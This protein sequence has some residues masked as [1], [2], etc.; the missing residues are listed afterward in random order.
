MK[1]VIKEVQSLIRCFRQVAL[2]F[3]E[4][5]CF[6]VPQEN[7]IT[8]FQSTLIVRFYKQQRPGAIS[9]CCS[10]RLVSGPGGS[11]LRT[12][13]KL[14]GRKWRVLPLNN[15]QPVP[16]WARFQNHTNVLKSVD[17]ITDTSG[18]RRL[19]ASRQPITST[20]R[21]WHNNEWDIFQ[22]LTVTR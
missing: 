8:M 19:W 9:L 5:N 2:S 10:S 16:E 11:T 22:Y 7:V 20:V 12:Q 14:R 18:E 17:Y 13:T 3:C 15:T 6:V 1:F 4:Q 21:S